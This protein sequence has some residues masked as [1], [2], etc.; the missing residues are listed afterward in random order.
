[1]QNFAGSVALF[2]LGAVAVMGATFTN[3]GSASWPCHLAGGGL[4][5]ENATGVT[6]DFGCPP[7]TS[8]SGSSASVG[9]LS[10]QADIHILGIPLTMFSLQSTFT[11][12]LL[13]VGGSGPGMVEFILTY[14]YTGLVDLGSAQGAADLLFNGVQVINIHPPF[15]TAP[16]PS[17]PCV[18]YTQPQQIVQVI[19]EPITYG[20]PFTYQADDFLSGQGMILYD[21][22]NGLAI[23][24][25]LPTGG[26]LEEV[27]EPGTLWLCTMGSLGLLFRL[28]SFSRHEIFVSVR[29]PAT[30]TAGV[31]PPWLR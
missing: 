19:D 16:P 3:T 17:V 31:E 4:V 7:G 13:P 14:S 8:P 22:S 12:S 9:N 10:A 15:C 24:T 11:D 18:Q 1:M 29:E 5:Q 23:S 28:A 25:S 20:V 21:L 27:P 2:I 6:F 30:P 26:T